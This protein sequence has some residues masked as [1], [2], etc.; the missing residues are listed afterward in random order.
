MTQKTL[1]EQTAEVLEKFDAYEYS[2]D[3]HG[4]YNYAALKELHRLDP[5]MMGNLIRKWQERCEAAEL[6]ISNA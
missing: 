5:H 6:E 1:E 2:K 4:Y 3:M